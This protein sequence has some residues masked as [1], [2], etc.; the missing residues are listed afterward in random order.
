MSDIDGVNLASVDLNLLVALDALLHEVHVGAAARA[1]GLSQPA[2]SHA[3][4]RLRTLFADELLVRTGTGMRLTSRGEA[5]RAPV[6]AALKGLAAV[7]K[8]SSFDPATSTRHFKI[9]LSD[10]TSALLAPAL[11]LRLAGEAPRVR[12]DIVPWD[13]DAARCLERLREVDAALSCELEPYASLRR[14]RVF[15]DRDALVA[16]RDHP[17]RARFGDAEAVL[18]TPHVAVIEHDHEQDPVDEWLSSIGLERALSASVPQY[19]LALQLVAK[20][21]LLAIVPERLALQHARSLGLEVLPV[22]LDIGHFDEFMLHGER[23]HEDPGS[24][25]LRQTIASICAALPATIAP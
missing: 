8:P 21:E 12:V 11:L 3:L 25:W 5:L 13:R 14:Q 1:V 16:R 15:Q 18:G 20:S 24:A 9:M 7:L 10:Y 2:M 23:T 6:R 17:Q 19:L 22:P 4:R